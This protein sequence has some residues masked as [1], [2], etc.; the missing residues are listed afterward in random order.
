MAA[1]ASLLAALVAAVAVAQAGV[2]PPPAGPAA[3][4]DAADAPGSPLDLTSVTFGQ[5][6]DRLVLSLTTSGDW[7]ADQ[8]A[9]ARGRSLCVR[10]FRGTLP[11]PRA[12]ICVIAAGAG[13]ALRYT[14]LDAAGHPSLIRPIVA[15]VARP[16]T[17]SLQATFT[18]AAAGLAIGRYS[19]QAHS[20]WTDPATCAGAGGC[21]DL[22]PDAGNVVD[23]IAPPAVPAGCVAGG[24]AQL[25]FGSRRAREVALTFDDGPSSYTPAIVTALEHAHVPATFFEVGTSVPGHGALLRRMLRDGFMIGNH[26]LTHANVAD[27]GA[28]AERQLAATQA[29]IKRTSGF[30]PC[31]FRPPGGSTSAALEAV[32]G[33]FGMVSILWDVDPADWRTPGTAAIVASVLSH[34]RPGSIILLHDGGGPRGQTVAAVPTIIRALQARRL[35][36]VTVAQLLHLQLRSA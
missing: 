29:I 17:R 33:S 23:R 12:R 36:L 15:N 5:V 10:I 4:A 24:P 8:L 27:G 19:W 31:L 11:V 6:R 22:V 3:H 14:R 13:T 9:A 21:A 18:P 34:A 25:R 20:R 1:A 7:S 28:F 32:A 35:K 16:D 30:E 2:A 26:T